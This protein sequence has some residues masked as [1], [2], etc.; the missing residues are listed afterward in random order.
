MWYKF[1]SDTHENEHGSFEIDINPSNKGHKKFKSEL[2][3]GIFMA[4]L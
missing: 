2:N 4:S 3:Q 1:Q